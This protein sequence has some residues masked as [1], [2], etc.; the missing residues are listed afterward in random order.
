MVT[1]QGNKRR[2]QDVTKIMV[3]GYHV[4]LTDE[5]KM[6]EMIVD[7][8]GPKDSAYEGVS[9][10]KWNLIFLTG[11]LESTSL[12]AWLVPDKIAFNRLYQQNIPSQYWRSVSNPKINNF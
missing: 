2:D 8:P 4:E 11:S 5:N 1:A 7:F 10:L 3:S 6:N 9:K 12:A